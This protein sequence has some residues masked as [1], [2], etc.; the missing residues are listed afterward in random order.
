MENLSLYA[1]LLEAASNANSAFIKSEMAINDGNVEDSQKYSKDGQVLIR[2][3][4]KDTFNEIDEL[5]E[6]KGDINDY[7]YPNNFELIKSLN[8]ISIAVGA[9]LAAQED[10]NIINIILP[11]LFKAANTTKE[12]FISLFEN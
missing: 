8:D 3:L 5:G 12:I 1:E 2:A 7:D 11:S 9:L 4:I 10:E 6:N